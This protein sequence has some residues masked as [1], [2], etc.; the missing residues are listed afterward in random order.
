LL[1]ASAL[2]LFV[3]LAL[4][5]WTAGNVIH[6]GYFANLVLLGSFLGIGIGFL[7]AG[8]GRTR[9]PWFSFIALAA[10]VT[11]LLQ[12]PVVVER[13]G[14]DVVFFTS[15]SLTGPP[16]WLV[17]PGV[18]VVVAVVL[19]GPGQLVGQCFGELPRLEAYRLDLIGS[20]TGIVAFSGL[21]F[22]RA[23]SVVWGAVVA[24]AVLV[25][26]GRRP[27]VPGAVAM[28]L[29]VV[30]LAMETATAGVSWSPYN[31]IQ[32][33]E[34]GEGSSR[35]VEI[36]ANGVPHQAAISLATRADADPQYLLPYQRRAAKDGP[37]DVLI[38]GAGSGNDVALALAQGATSVTAVEIDPRIQQIG[39]ERHPSA[40]YDDPRVEVHID[41]GRAFLSR[42]SRQFDTILFALPDSLTLV[43]GASQ[44]RLES[45]LFTVE[46]MEA[47]R[48]RLAPGGTFS[49]YNFYREEWLIG[50]LANTTEAAFGHA[51]CVDVLADRNRAVVSI[52]LAPADQVCSEVMDRPDGP[53]AATDARPFLY[54]RDASIPPVYLWTILGIVLISL[55]GV[56]WAAG[57]V[58]S[59]LPYRDLF[60]LGAAFLLLETRS[61]ATFA[62]LFG[63]T[64]FVNAIVFGGVLLVVL[65]A[66]EVTA[67]WRT[68][69]LPVM[70]AVLAGT[71]VLAAVVPQASLLEL[72]PVPRAV[73]AIA[74]AFAPIFTANVIF[75]KRFADTAD[76]AS[77]FGANLLGAM[78]GGCLEYIALIIGYPALIGLAALLY[79]G[80]FAVTPRVKVSV[81][82]G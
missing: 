11:V 70:Y 3:E 79:L 43:S 58:R 12:Y 62:L 54:L 63:T 38:V 66:V 19:I 37:G 23:P 39:A 78:V 24:I 35:V 41:D 33:Q 26:A 80:A 74:L 71:L 4:I 32:T 9:F 65:L 5:R 6:L 25:L 29:L 67:R 10:L 61:V 44:I 57:S 76:G 56:R 17:L 34:T 69:P 53:T 49:M 48:D 82:A 52:G 81:P 55:L 40:P 50:R 60:L 21:A 72:A 59:L 36:S 68:P 51:P 1:L 28:V 42:T 14:S 18:F 13:G 15:L 31:K 27:P 30:M 75:A 8:R 7:R 77:A 47:V 16:A 46:A 22:L 64:W 2:M 73:V 20:L 45:Y